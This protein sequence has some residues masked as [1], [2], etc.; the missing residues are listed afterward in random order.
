[1][2][3]RRWAYSVALAVLCVCSLACFWAAG[4]AQATAYT[5][6]KEPVTNPSFG[7]ASP[8]CEDVNGYP[9][10]ETLTKYEVNYMLYWVLRGMQFHCETQ[11]TD[12]ERISKRLWWVTAELLHVQ[13][14]QDSLK[15]E[16]LKALGKE[17]TLHNDLTTLHNDLAAK[18]GLPVALQGNAK[19]TP[20][21]TESTGVVSIEDSASAEY[22][23]ELVSAVDASG[24]ASKAGLYM[25]IGVVVASFVAYA[26]WKTS[27]RGV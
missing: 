1:M 3:L 12:Q 22:S 26:L 17:G 11:H 8:P 27:D 20:L 6:P 14:K 9:N 19:A 13:E 23:G 25:L 7:A 5:E 4:S 18:G 15:A 16:V 10:V 21:Y 2:A 24:E